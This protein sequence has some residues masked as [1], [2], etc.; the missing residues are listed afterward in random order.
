MQF[1]DTGREFR[2]EYCKISNE[3][4]TPIYTE[5]PTAYDQLMEALEKEQAPN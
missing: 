5:N 3:T 2:F 1:S 4:R